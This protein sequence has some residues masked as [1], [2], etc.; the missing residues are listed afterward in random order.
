MA[1]PLRTLRKTRLKLRLIF[2][3]YVIVRL[4]SG[5]KLIN[6]HEQ[7]FPSE[8][9]KGSRAGEVSIRTRAL[10]WFI[11]SV[12]VTLSAPMTLP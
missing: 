4:G 11:T 8:M 9:L 12:R 5:H 2:I 7:C 6:R 3:V 1:S 10:V